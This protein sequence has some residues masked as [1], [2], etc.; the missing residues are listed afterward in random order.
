MNL[1]DNLQYLR[2]RD[3]LT[4]EEL[5]DKLGVSRQAVSKWETG[6]AYPET[7]KLMLL[8]DLFNVSL[9]GLMRSNLSELCGEEKKT[10][11]SKEEYSKHFDSF[12]RAV[13][14]GVMLI[15]IG[16]AVCVA[17]A[18]YA[19]T[20]KERA[21]N[22]VETLG[23]A[24]VVLFVAVAVFLF[25][26][27]GMGHERFKKENPSVNGIFGEK[28]IKSFEKR[29]SAAMACFVSG[30]LLA[31]V[32]LIVFFA[33]LDSGII[34]AENKDGAACYLTA[35]FLAALAFCVGGLIYF[36]IQH[37]KYNI[38]E[39]NKQVADELNPSPRS[40]LSSKLCGAVM[41]SA[42]ALFL[43]LGLVWQL[44]NICWVVFP[45]GG[46]ICAIISTILKSRD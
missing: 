11:I 10:E 44:W 39:Y 33:L 20:L 38:S 14:I 43:V 34:G 45:V 3:K 5:A 35:A 31:V 21:A 15:L 41:L 18:G 46:I 6:E 2:K 8:C 22:A 7:E 32:L 27:F 19:T 29:F 13:A 17:L 37:Y 9:D 36:G 23:G 28:E 24:A 12:S 16:V 25:V 40:K 42:T 4:Q 30:I 26:F 1:V